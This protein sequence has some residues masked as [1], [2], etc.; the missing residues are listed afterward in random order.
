MQLR[1]EARFLP[2]AVVGRKL[3][4]MLGVALCFPDSVIVFLEV[5]L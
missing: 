3:L 4:L 1:P 5:V 2:L